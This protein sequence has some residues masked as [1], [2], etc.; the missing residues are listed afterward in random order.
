MFRF[1]L[2]TATAPS[3]QH[4]YNVGDLVLGRMRSDQT[5]EAIRAINI[6]TSRRN[7]PVLRVNPALGTAAQQ[8]NR[9]LL[10]SILSRIEQHDRSSLEPT[11][12]SSPFSFPPSLSCS[13]PRW[14]SLLTRLTHDRPTSR[15]S[16]AASTGIT[17]RQPQYSRTT[18]F[19]SAR[20]GHSTA[21]PTLLF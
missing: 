4:Q 18:W 19:N 10:P 7:F 8:H 17:P 3:P 11:P 21:M 15:P 20:T 13:D 14:L 16:S 1:Q 9:K 5:E 6:P 12:V 2:R